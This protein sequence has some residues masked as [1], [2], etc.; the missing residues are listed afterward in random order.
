MKHLG[1]ADDADKYRWLKVND[2]KK[3]PRFEK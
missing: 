1:L 3:N 2:N